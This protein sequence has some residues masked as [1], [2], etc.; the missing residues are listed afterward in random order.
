MHLQDVT[1]WIE[2][3]A[4]F[5]WAKRFGKLRALL[6]SSAYDPTDGR[7]S[8]LACDPV[9]HI[10]DPTDLCS[11]AFAST[12]ADNPAVNNYFGYIGYEALQLIEPTVPIAKKAFIGL[13]DIWLCRFRRVYRFDA[14]HR[15]VEI[16]ADNACRPPFIPEKTRRHVPRAVPP[17]SHFRALMKRNAY[18]D[19]VAAILE[20]IRAGDIFQ[21]NLTRKYIGEF[22]A[23]PD[24][25]AIYARMCAVTP[26]HYA[27]FLSTPYADILSS[28]PENFIRIDRDGVMRASPIKG[29]AP[30]DL[31]NPK[32]DALN[33]ETLAHSEK[34][35]AE[36]TM[37]VDLYRNDMSRSCLPGSV[38]VPTLCAVHSFSTVHHMVSTVIGKKRADVT[39]TQAIMSAFPPGS[40]TGAPKPYAMTLCHKYEGGIKRGAYSGVIGR[41]GGDGSA[42]FSVV[43]RTMI[44]K[45]KYMECQTGGGIVADS[46]PYAE[47]RETAT[48]LRGLARALGEEKRMIRSC[49]K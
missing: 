39:A 16:Y 44:L 6:H 21:A 32:Q 20:H 33:A 40:M 23:A 2:P 48:K 35:R 24:P 8:W 14:L 5:K 4:L 10:T 22:A 34:D 11:G 25:E 28:S 37:I 31:R 45:G 42:D 26:G 43:I 12:H 29:T 9:E 7:Y 36:N 13:P 18:I 38:K 30:R 46:R 47:L 41:I 49:L 3:T 27:A 15:T 1:E 17:L 19:R